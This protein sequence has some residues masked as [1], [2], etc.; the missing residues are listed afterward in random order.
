MRSTH[1]RLLNEF[2]S[3]VYASLFYLCTFHPRERRCVVCQIGVHADLFFF[4][5]LIITEPRNATTSVRAMTSKKMGIAT[6]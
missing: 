6:A 2:E 5:F 3:H 1:N 4:P